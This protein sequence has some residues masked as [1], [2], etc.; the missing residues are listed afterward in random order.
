MLIY[1]KNETL[2]PPAGFEVDGVEPHGAYLV[3]SYHRSEEEKDHF[4]IQLVHVYLNDMGR[5]V[6]RT[7]ENALDWKAEPAVAV[8][9]SRWYRFC[10]GWL[11]AL[12]GLQEMWSCLNK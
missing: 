2:Q 3:L 6:L 9:V 10:N 1:D 4:N 12:Q 7:V 8:T 5:E 11:I